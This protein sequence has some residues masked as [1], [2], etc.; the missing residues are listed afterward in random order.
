MYEGEFEINESPVTYRIQDVFG[1][2]PS[3]FAGMFEI[4]LDKADAFVLVY[5]LDDKESWNRISELRDTIHK[6]TSQ[7]TFQL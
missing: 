5:A 2:Y 7:L 1:H 4:S 3:D 6:E